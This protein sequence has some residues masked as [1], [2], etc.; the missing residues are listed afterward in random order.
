MS[1]LDPRVDDDSEKHVDQAVAGQEE[2]AAAAHVAP[3]V[4]ERTDGTRATLTEVANSLGISAAVALRALRGESDINDKLIKTVHEAAE[5]LHYP[6]EDLTNEDEHHG[7]V[8]VLVNTMRNTWI[9]DLVRSIRI[10]LSAT[11]R[12]VVVVP[13]RQRM[14]EY[15]VAVDASAI[16]AL[17]TLG[18]DGFIMASELPELDKVFD[19]VGQ[20]PV[21][22]I[23]GSMTNVGRCDTVRIDDE[24]GMGLL[25][26]HLVDLGHRDIA[27]VGGVGYAVS[28]ERAEAFKQAMK[29]HGLADHAR[30]EP[31]DFSEQVGQTAG[32]MLLRGSQVP[33]AITCSNDVSAVG[34]LSAADDAGFEVPAELAVTGFGNTSLASSGVAQITSVDPNSR[35]IGALG[36]QFL[37]ERVGGYDGPARDE[38]VSPQLVVRRSSSAGPRPER[39]RRRRVTID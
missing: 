14:P 26:D 30:V 18:V 6:L 34:V 21:V 33:T 17:V 2:Q 9:S 12:H 25:V 23:G 11:G 16:K 5:R 15:P 29:R 24:A 36:A 20:R 3:E 1:T 39:Q 4:P 37:V 35:R 19:A 7:V 22:A 10:E 38:A 27:H 28:R 31:A 13:T 32:S 8:A